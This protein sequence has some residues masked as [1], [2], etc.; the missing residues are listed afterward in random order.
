M[1]RLIE[2]GTLVERCQQRADKVNDDHVS[3]AEWRALISEV[4]GSDIFSTVAETGYRY[5][6]YVASITTTGAAYVSEPDDHL[7]TIRLDYVASTTDRRQLHQVMPGEE[8]K[9][10][11][12]TGTEP[13][14]YALIDDRI[15]LYPTPVSG[16]TLEMRYVPQPPDLSTYADSDPVDVVSPDGEACLVWGVAALAR[17][18]ASQDVTLHLA[19]S[20]RHKEALQLWAARRGASLRRVVTDIDPLYDIGRDPGDW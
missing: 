16:L 1:P 3:A 17:A 11:S 2:M 15:Y 19:K 5:F 13:V 6:E 9:L 14:Y 18:K 8:P 12:L 20:E 10:A 7:E 4:Y